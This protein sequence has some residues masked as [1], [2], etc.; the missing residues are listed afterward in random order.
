VSNAT[1]STDRWQAPE[2]AAPVGVVARKDLPQSAQLPDDFDPLAEGILMAHQRAW[3]EDKS[4]LKICEKGRRTG[5]TFAEALDDTLIAATRKSDGGQNVFYIGDTKEK[6][7]E[8]IGYCAHFAR[9]VAKE[10]V[11]VE[12]YLFEDRDESGDS[13]FINAYRIHFASGRRIHALSSRPA[14]IRGLQG[15]VVID[16]AAFHKD[17][18]QVIAAVNALLIWGGKIRIISSHNGVENAFNV[19]ITETKAGKWPYSVHRYTF[20]DAVAN[21]LYERVCMMKR[22][23]PTPEGKKRWYDLIVGSYGTDTEGRDEELFCI[24]RKSGGTFI[25]RV[26]VEARADAAIPVVR[27]IKDTDFAQQPVQTREADIKAW[28]EATLKPLLATLDPN[29]PSFF[30]EDFGRSVDRTVI[31]PAQLTREMLRRAPFVVELVNVPFE[32][33]KQILFYILDRLPRFAGGAMDATGNGAYLAEV[34]WQKYGSDLIEQIKLSEAWYREHMPKLKAAFADGAIA[35]PTDLDVI[36]DFGDL[37]LVNGVAQVP[38][39]R[40]RVGSDGRARHGDT[41][42]AA[43]L[44]IYASYRTPI[45]YEY[46]A[47][48]GGGDPRRRMQP[49]DAEDARISGLFREGAY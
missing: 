12:E 9:V 8:F 30:G 39:T 11:Q 19:I 7:L 28:C 37:K 32:Q 24:P 34:T 42:I 31:W 1:D 36:D 5:I 45:V 18:G 17:V 29:L 35:V 48:R 25:P 49:D 33:Q 43:A 15:I 22:E 2:L 23:K 14:S 10:L 21:G 16:E 4:D 6:G 41:A 3:L 47:A 26:L 20:D 40:R 27:L 38:A 13:R 46:T 44:M